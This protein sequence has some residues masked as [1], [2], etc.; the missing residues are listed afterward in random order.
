MKYYEVDV[1]FAFFA[2]FYLFFI[3]A[4]SKVSQLTW[5][6]M[7]GFVSSGSLAVGCHFGWSTGEERER[8]CL[9]AHSMRER[10][11]VGGL[12]AATLSEGGARLAEGV[13]PQQPQRRRTGR[14]GHANRDDS[15]TLPSAHGERTC[16]ANEPEGCDK[17]FRR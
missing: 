10:T 3:F 12:A 15:R 14:R 9:L 5:R 6:V 11:G 8:N 16:T 7:N 17:T 4:K 1:T 2:F 13:R